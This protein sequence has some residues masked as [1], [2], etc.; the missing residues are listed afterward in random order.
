MFKTVKMDTISLLPPSASSSLDD[1][2]LR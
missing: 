1:S 2:V